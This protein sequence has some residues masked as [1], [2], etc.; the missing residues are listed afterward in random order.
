MN[1]LFGNYPKIKIKKANGKFIFYKNKKYLDLSYASGSLL[2]GHTS[3]IF[4]NS[5]K[6]IQKVGS[7]YSSINVY[8]EEFSKILKKIFPEFSKFIM[9]STG[10]EAN[11]K[12]LRIARAITKRKKIVMVTGSW[13][14]SVDELLYTSNDSE[15]KFKNKL[16]NGL[17]D[18]KNTIIVPY[19][20][21]KLSEKI[22]NKN[23]NEIAL[24]IIEPIQ[25]ALPTIISD[26]YVEF[27]HKYSKKNKILICFDEMITGLRV[28]EFSIYKK[29][30]IIP[31]LIT[32]GKIFGGGA[33]IGVIGLTNDIEKKII[34]KKYEVFFGGTFSLNP[35]SSI[36]GFNTTKFILDNK[37]HIYEKL[38]YLSNYLEKSLNQFIKLKNINAQIIRYSS[39]IRI[40]FTKKNVLSKLEKDKEENKYVKKINKFKNYIYDN[41]I[42]L[43]KNGAIFLSLQNSKKDIDY[44]IKVFRKGFYKFL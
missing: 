26:K 37:H 18:C 21:I 11:M 34:K 4:K 24:I 9:C 39:I 17:L 42:F 20:N 30:K 19:N 13:H 7:N 36:L 32:F 5:L 23:K 40:I 16:S 44:I 22:L 27:L 29:L 33:P 31:D 8:A 12:A 28:P 43:S 14:G 15:C 10:T 25:Q 35:L 41:R 2:L 6:K 38:E 3:K 1:Y